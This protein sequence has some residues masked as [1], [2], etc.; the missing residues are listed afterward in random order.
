MLPLNSQQAWAVGLRGVQDCVDGDAMLQNELLNQGSIRR[1]EDVGYGVVQP[2]DDEV[3]LYGRL[4][5][6]CRRAQAD[7][8]LQ[9]IAFGLALGLV[10]LGYVQMRRGGS[11]GGR[12]AYVA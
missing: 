10:G 11:Y 5:G 6:N 3:A 8:V 9:F 2:G 12:G 4:Q 7:E 1:G